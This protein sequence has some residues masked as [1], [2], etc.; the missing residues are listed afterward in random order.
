MKTQSAAT[1][2]LWLAACIPALGQYTWDLTQSP[3]AQDPA[4]WTQ[5]GSVAFGSPT[6]FSSGGALIYNQT[7]SGLNSNDY[8]IDATYS[9]KSGGGSYIQFVRADQG[10]SVSS[11]GGM[12]TCYGNSVFLDIGIAP[13][14]FNPSG[15]T[16]L[17]SL[18]QCSSGT[19][20][21][22]V[23]TLI[24]VH[25]GMTT[26]VVVWNTN[27][28]LFIDGVLSLQYSLPAGLTGNPGIGGLD[29]PSG[30]GFTA[31]KVGRHDTVAPRWINPNTVGVSALPNQVN[32]QWAGTTDD[33]NGIG[34]FTYTVS[35]AMR[36]GTI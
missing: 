16:E 29:Q 7:I 19:M 12:T 14:N 27:L 28:F 24:G 33:A 18:F 31:I 34:L 11:S 5:N 15:A 20:T 32:L 10:S 35:R 17:M 23:G 36:R 13:W 8:E 25:D 21:Y 1:L 9:L 3:V 2:V 26:Q 6:T 22:L 4:H 30:S